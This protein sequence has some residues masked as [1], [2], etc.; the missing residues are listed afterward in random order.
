MF[1][2]PVNQL[3]RGWVVYLVLSQSNKTVIKTI[4]EF[5]IRRT[6]QL[7]LTPFPFIVCLFVL[8]LFQLRIHLVL[9]KYL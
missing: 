3:F 5:A 6:A 2:E 7:V 9:L 8:Y 4:L 1:F